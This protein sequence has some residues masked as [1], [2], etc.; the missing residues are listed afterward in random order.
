MPMRVERVVLEG[1]DVEASL[2]ASASEWKSRSTSAEATYS[3]VA[4]P[5]LKV[6]AAISR[7]SSSSGIGS[8][9]R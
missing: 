5:W 8:P 6:R 3:T 7:R 2:G 4:Q 1:A 9:V